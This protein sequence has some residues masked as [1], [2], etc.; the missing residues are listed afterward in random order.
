MVWLNY[1][2]KFFKG[3][4]G[5]ENP[6]YSSHLTCS[7]CAECDRVISEGEEYYFPFED[8]EQDIPQFPD[9]HIICGQCKKKRE[10]IKIYRKR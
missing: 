10:N 1:K 3:V 8:L 7:Y 2:I 4:T 5:K 9:G 6:M